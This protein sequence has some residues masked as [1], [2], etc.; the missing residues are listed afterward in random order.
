MGYST[1]TGT[2]GRFEQE[3]RQKIKQ[4]LDADMTDHT[5]QPDEKGLRS[6]L[7][8]NAVAKPETETL[9]ALRAAVPQYFDKDGSFLK[10]R[11]DADL[12]A[13]GTTESPDGYRLNF[14]GKDYARLQSGLS[15]ENLLVPDS[16]HNAQ[17]GNA[18]S[19]NIFITGDNLEA[20][21]HLQNAYSGAVKVIYIDPPYN[22]GQEFVYSDNFEWK[23]E[24]LK[25][26]L[27]Y[28][29]EE[30]KRLH[31]INGK[32]SHSA[33]LTFMYPRLKI[34]RRLLRDDGVIFISID[35]NE[36]ANLRLLMDE[37]FGEQNFVA[38][39]VWQKRTSPDARLNLGPAHDYIFVFAKCIRPEI[40]IFNQLPLSDERSMQYKNPDNDPRGDWASV[41]IT[42][43]TGHATES[44][45]YEITTPSGLKLVP[46][47]G[48]LMS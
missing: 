37:I 33:W 11:F 48:I 25:E 22:T 14:V 20:L 4:E 27:G 34:A 13:S 41:D 39:I 43:Q 6:I 30:I 10:A 29:D 28:S 35:D 5:T 1:I 18:N 38:N 23:D 21:R 12:A 45:F 15:S 32:A 8:R 44:Q 36:Q 16:E 9:D 7:E 19:G 26:R 46:P 24:D 31:S 42:G 40:S 47:A 2:A 3:R 17:P